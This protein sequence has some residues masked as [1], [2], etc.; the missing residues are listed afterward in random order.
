[1][2]GGFGEAAVFRTFDEP[3]EIVSLAGTLSPEGL[4]V[5]IS[6]SRRDG[7]CVGGHFLLGCVVN[8]LRNW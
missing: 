1:M 7:A 6:L 3:M 5:H 2:P 4:H 8:T